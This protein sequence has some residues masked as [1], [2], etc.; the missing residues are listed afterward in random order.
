M[1]EVGS[2][3][4]EANGVAQ[5]VKSR[6]EKLK[7]LG[8]IPAK[9]QAKAQANPMVAL[10]SVAAA[11]FVLGG[12]VGSRLGRFALA[13]SLPVVV[14]HALD[15]SLARELTRIAEALTEEPST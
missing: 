5:K 15:G 12:L 10:A 11:A 13:A 7:V 4:A 1:N 9:L 8:A 14:S 2:H 3:G 6:I